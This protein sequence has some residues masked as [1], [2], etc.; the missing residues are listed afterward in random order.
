MLTT[1][2]LPREDY[3]KLQPTEAGAVWD[4]LPETAQVLAVERDGALVGA[5]VLMP[6]WHAEGL[7]IAPEERGKATVARRLWTFMQARVAALGLSRVA[8]HACSDEIRGLLEHVQA[9]EVPGQMFLI[10]IGEE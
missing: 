7:W 6:V 3:A 4:Q 2:L 1:R 8:T 10:P 5:W 9:T